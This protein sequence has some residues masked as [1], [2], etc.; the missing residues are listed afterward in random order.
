MISNTSYPDSSISS[1][2][3]SLLA[4]QS[5]ALTLTTRGPCPVFWYSL[6]PALSC[7]LFLFCALNWFTFKLSHDCL[8]SS[9]LLWWYLSPWVTLTACR[10]SSI[11]LGSP[12]QLEKAFARKG[13]PR[14]QRP[15]QLQINLPCWGTDMLYDCYR[16]TRGGWNTCTVHRHNCTHKL[17]FLR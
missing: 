11:V 7:L 2:D 5:L 10:N 1:S 16:S 8:M 4:S 12:Q 3:Y 13:P 9:N 15:G 6:S 14:R 17:V